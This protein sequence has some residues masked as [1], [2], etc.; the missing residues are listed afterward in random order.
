MDLSSRDRPC[1]RRILDEESDRIG[2]RNR[3]SIQCVAVI[4]DDA[5]CRRVISRLVRSIGLYPVEYGS[6]VEF[7]ESL[8]KTAPDV[9]VL[10]NRL[11]SMSGL[12]LQEQLNRQSFRSPIIFLSGCADVSVAVDAMKHGA[13]DFI[14]KPVETQRFID[15]VQAAV[16]RSERERLLSER[17]QAEIDRIGQLTGRQVEVLELMVAGHPN[18]VI[19]AELGL[20]QRTVEVHRAALMRKLGVDSLAEAVRSY[21][22]AQDGLRN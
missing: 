1:G 16:A 22:I 15:S 9:V 6:A 10:D 2:S 18:K 7:L 12:A 13:F 11:P 21:W 19:A 14:T 3:E 17:V 8:D 4:D 5:A 20:S